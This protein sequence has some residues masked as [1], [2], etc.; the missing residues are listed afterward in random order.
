LNLPWLS[1]KSGSESLLCLQILEVN[2]FK[3]RPIALLAA[4]ALKR[5]PGGVTL[6]KQLNYLEIK[7]AAAMSL[8]MEMI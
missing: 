1:P 7:R 2:L 6:G 3:R 5:I 8:C 4:K